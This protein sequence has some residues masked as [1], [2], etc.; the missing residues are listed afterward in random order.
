M[1]GFRGM[2]VLLHCTKGIVILSPLCVNRAAVSGR[3]APNGASEARHPSGGREGGSPHAGLGRRLC[4]YV[5]ERRADD[6]ERRGPSQGTHDGQRGARHND[7]PASVYVYKG[8]QYA[9]TKR[10]AAA[11]ALRCERITKNPTSTRPSI[12]PSRAVEAA[13]GVL[14][15]INRSR[16]C[17][18]T[19]QL[20][21]VTPAAG[22]AHHEDRWKPL[23]CR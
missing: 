10:D 11:S 13:G 15:W 22:I 7:K 4:R 14:E 23:S 18:T 2:P 6:G 12:G 17:T 8:R 19:P 1:A 21:A 3:R 5:M 9:S 16:S 20:W